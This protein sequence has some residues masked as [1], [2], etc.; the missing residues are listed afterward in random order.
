MAFRFWTKV[1][2]LSRSECWP[3][4][5]AK[6]KNGYGAFTIDGIRSQAHRAAFL[7]CK[8]EIPPDMLVLHSCDNRSCVNPDHLFLGTT[9]GQLS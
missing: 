8:G 2:K 7:I 5:G 6:R 1:E 9:A 3:W 4:V